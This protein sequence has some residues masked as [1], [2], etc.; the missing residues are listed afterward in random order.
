QTDVYKSEI[1]NEDDGAGKND[2]A[3]DTEI[4]EPC[5]VVDSDVF[6]D[7]SDVSTSIKDDVHMH[8]STVENPAKY[9]NYD[10]SKG[11]NDVSKLNAASRNFQSDEWN[12]KE[13]NNN[14]H[15]KEE[16]VQ[17]HVT[18]RDGDQ[19]SAGNTEVGIKTNDVKTSAVKTLRLVLIGQTGAGKSSTGNTLL[20]V[21]KF[22]RSSSSKSCTEVSQREST[23]KRGL[24]LEVIDTP[25]L[26]DTHKPP[27]ELR[28]E[29][30]NCMMMT[31][32][33]PHVFLLILKMNRITE[34]E[35]KTLRYLKEIFGGDQFLSYTIIVITRKEDFEET[36]FKN[37]EKTNEDIHELFQTTLENSPDLHHM[38]RQC[39]NRYFLLSNKGR[40]D[41]IKRTEQANQLMSLILEMTQ[42]NKNTFYS[43]QYFIELEE[44][45]KQKLK[46]EAEKKE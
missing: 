18:K 43:Y 16:F 3:T 45:R 28:K 19:N 23:V 37:T 42:E 2:K 24:I 36:C 40:V 30:S 4:K 21:N 26:F 33:G 8:C 35:K 5:S 34:Q 10:A 13:E 32:P 38:V 44:E 41:G 46:R 29:F 9:C 17:E 11:S 6:D 15:L 27:E 31:N 20:G 1:V 12:G 25:G 14:K 39:K 22:N 7:M